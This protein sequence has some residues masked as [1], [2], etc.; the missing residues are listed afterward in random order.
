MTCCIIPMKYYRLFLMYVL[1]R[2]KMHV[3]LVSQQTKIMEEIRQHVLLTICLI[4]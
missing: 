2:T 1:Q 3:F 4:L